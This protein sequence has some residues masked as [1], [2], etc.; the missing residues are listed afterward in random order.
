MWCF[1]RHHKRGRAAALGHLEVQTRID[2]EGYGAVAFDS[3][4]RNDM[5][6][7]VVAPT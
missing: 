6:A 3:S 7:E 5:F 2:F 4:I 1:K